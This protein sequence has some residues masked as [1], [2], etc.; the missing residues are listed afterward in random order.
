MTYLESL[1]RNLRYVISIIHVTIRQPTE[2]RDNLEIT[3]ASFIW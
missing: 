2:V 3:F 1:I